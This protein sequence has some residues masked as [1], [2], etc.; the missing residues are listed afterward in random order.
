MAKFKGFKVGS[1]VH[2]VHPLNPPTENR[3]GTVVNSD[4]SF[5]EYVKD[6]TDA[7]WNGGKVYRTYSYMLEVVEPNDCVK[8]IPK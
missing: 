8:E 7:E 1:R 6:D 3:Y 5:T 4:A 2:F